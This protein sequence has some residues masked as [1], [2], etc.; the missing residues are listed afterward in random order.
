MYML[1]IISSMVLNVFFVVI[2][3][4]L[5]NSNVRMR[6]LESEPYFLP[7]IF[8]HMFNYIKHTASWD[9]MEFMRNELRSAISKL[10]IIRHD[11]NNIRLRKTKPSSNV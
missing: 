3:I 2:I 7:T 4:K 1:A 10:D 11:V 6:K 8:N 5:F 9:E